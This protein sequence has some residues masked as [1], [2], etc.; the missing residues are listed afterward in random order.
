MQGSWSEVDVCGQRIAAVV[1]RCKPWPL[2]GV[3]K[4]AH[5][6]K[7]KCWLKAFA[8]LQEYCKGGRFP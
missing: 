5:F 3:C 4:W 7:Q 8:E 1:A 2:Q 6:K